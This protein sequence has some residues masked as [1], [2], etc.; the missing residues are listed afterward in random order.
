M[1]CNAANDAEG[2]QF[3]SVLSPSP[4]PSPSS[5][6]RHTGDLNTSDRANEGFGFDESGSIES[7]LR[8]LFSVADLNKDG[9]IS[10]QEFLFSM[11]G[12]DYYL[13]TAKYNPKTNS[14]TTTVDVLDSE[15]ENSQ[16]SSIRSVTMN[17][18][19]ESSSKSSDI[20]IFHARRHSSEVEGIKS[21]Q[22]L[23]THDY[24]ACHNLPEHCKVAVMI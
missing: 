2:Q 13:N 23:T 20:N 4:S 3:T 21:F 14:F 6:K 18:K 22:Y 5:S 16:A 24:I 9:L 15:K 11:T 19:T 8:K 10:Y 17:G 7:K 12:F 1:Q